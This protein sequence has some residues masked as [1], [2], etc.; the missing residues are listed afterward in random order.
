MS[1]AWSPRRGTSVNVILTPPPPHADPRTN[2]PGCSLCAGHAI[3]GATHA[4]PHFC[5]RGRRL[6]EAALCITNRLGTCRVMIPSIA[7]HGKGIVVPIAPIHQLLICGSVSAG[8]QTS[9]YTDAIVTCARLLLVCFFFFSNGTA[10]TSHPSWGVGGTRKLNVALSA[11]ELSLMA[12]AS[13]ML[14]LLLSDILRTPS[15]FMQGTYES[16]G[17]IIVS[18]MVNNG[19]RV[20]FFFATP[21]HMP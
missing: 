21:A 3:D 6:A 4:R 2:Q 1:T 20:H 8:V 12:R 15:S 13:V 11:A 7:Q 9:A 19:R 17:C 18:D 10:L 14:L 16:F 5:L